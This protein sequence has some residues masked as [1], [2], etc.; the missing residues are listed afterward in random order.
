MVSGFQYRQA[1]FEI[2]V[3]GMVGKVMIWFAA[4]LAVIAGI[5]AAIFTRSISRAVLVAFATFILGVC[6]SLIV[7]YSGLLGG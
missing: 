7:V 4:I 6:M 5:I 2:N 1:P 3:F